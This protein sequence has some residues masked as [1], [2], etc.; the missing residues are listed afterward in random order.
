MAEQK[1]RGI[2]KDITDLTDKEILESVHQNAFESD[3]YKHCMNV[4]Q[5]RSIQRSAQASKQLVWATWFLFAAT[6]LLLLGSIPHLVEF[7]KRTS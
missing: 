6:L 1:S 5:L 7:I 3:Y 4:L 2:P